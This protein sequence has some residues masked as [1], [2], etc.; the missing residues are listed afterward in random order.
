MTNMVLLKNVAQRLT[1]GPGVGACQRHVMKRCQSGDME[2]LSVN[3]TTVFLSS[4]YVQMDRV[5]SCA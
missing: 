3:V 5:S 1:S 4:L 2:G